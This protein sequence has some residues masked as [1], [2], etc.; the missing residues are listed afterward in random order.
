M[1]LGWVTISLSLERRERIDEPR[2]RVA[3][4]DDVIDV[5]A[6]RRNVRLRQLVRLLANLGIRR[7]NGIVALRDLAT[8]EVLDGTFRPHD[9]DLRRRPRDVVIAANVLR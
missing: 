4:I 1:L 7:G 3:R 6:A 2:A 8:K 5:P 9:G